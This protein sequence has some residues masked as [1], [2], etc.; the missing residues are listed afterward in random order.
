MID[1]HCHILPGLDDGATS[2]DES[3]AMAKGLVEIGYST[4]CCT[5]H[6][7]KGYYEFTPEQVREATLILQA[8]LDNAGIDLVLKSGMEYTLDEC[9]FD[10]VDDL[11][12]LGES[13]LVLCEAPQIPNSAVIEDGLRVIVEKGF[14]P[15]VAH[16]ER[17]KFFYEVLCARHAEPVTGDKNGKEDSLPRQSEG[18]LKKLF[19]FGRSSDSK[20]KIQNLKFTGEELPRQCLFQAN[21]ASFLGYYPSETQKHA[22]DLLK[23]GVFNCVASDLHNSYMARKVLKTGFEKLEVNPLLK[24]LAGIT[25]KELEAISEQKLLEEKQAEQESKQQEF[26]F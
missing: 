7:M 26:G 16:P 2:I 24:A 22:Y 18:F 19:G 21:I 5:P 8:D 12:P 11:L 3:I 13:R 1:Y 20:P 15:L 10:F 17:S 6:C 14:V 4:V 9:F 23:F 25:P